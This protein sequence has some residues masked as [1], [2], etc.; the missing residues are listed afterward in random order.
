VQLSI[1]GQTYRQKL[2]VKLDPRLKASIADLQSQLD[3]EQQI[4]RGM[5][6]SYQAYKDVAALRKALADHKNDALEK[7]IDAVDNGTHTAPGFGPINRD[8]TRLA[9]SVQS[10]DVRPA[11]TAA[12]AV[13]EK[14]KALD[15]ALAKW[16]TLN[17]QDLPAAHLPV[18][19]VNPQTCSATPAAP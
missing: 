19:T 1:A 17:E 5:S 2:I 18:V 14:C 15:D 3:I 7:K 11:E 10:A 4:A 13:A 12:A 16:R 9:A 6:T 8:L